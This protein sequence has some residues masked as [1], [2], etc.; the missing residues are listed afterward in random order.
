VDVEGFGLCND[1]EP[2]DL[3]CRLDFRA[4]Q[5]GVDVGVECALWK[6]GGVRRAA[7][8]AREEDDE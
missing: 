2:F 8:A 1:G 3:E 6:E 7:T 4:D 5:S